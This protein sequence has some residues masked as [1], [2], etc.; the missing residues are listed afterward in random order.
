MVPSFL[1]SLA[2]AA[3]CEVPVDRDATSAEV[4]EAEIALSRVDWRSLTERTTRLTEMLPCVSTRLLATDLAP[5]FRLRGWAL[6]SAGDPDAH[7]WLAS[8][9]GMQPGFVHDPPLR[10][11]M[12]AAWNSAEERWTGVETEELAAPESVSLVVN[13][14][15]QRTAPVGLPW[16]LQRLD[17]DGGVERTWLLGAKD[18]LPVF[19][20]APSAPP[21]MTAPVTVPEPPSATIRRRSRGLAVV[22]LAAG[23]AGTGGLVGAHLTKQTYKSNGNTALKTPNAIAGATGHAL[24]AVA[25]GLGTV[26]VI[27]GEW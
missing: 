11:P 1:Y 17:V 15:A 20:D 22:G 8:A 6:F 2:F 3:P 12:E 26:A 24:L 23:V 10:G 21:T 25:G 16:V 18:E 9:Y 5:V 4:A 7:A 14:V 27:R 13:G 19:E